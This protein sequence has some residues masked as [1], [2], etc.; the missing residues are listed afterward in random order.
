MSVREIAKRA[1]VSITTVSRVLNNHPSV[2]ETVRES[3]LA[4]A[5]DARYVAPVSRRSTTN[6]A[7][8]YT[9]PSSLGSSFDAALMAGMNDGLEEFGCD[10][11]ILDVVRSRNPGETF[12]QMFMRKGVRGAMLRTTEQ[13]RKLCETI[14]SENFPVLAVADRFDNPA[15]SFIHSDSRNVSRDG[16]EHL[17][18]LGH[19]RIAIS[20]NVVD[21]H[22]HQ[23]RLDGYKEA[24]TAAGIEVDRRLILRVP[25]NREGG[26][27]AMR[28]IMTMVDRP[29]ALFATD[30]MVAAGALGEAR[31]MQVKVPADL[32]IIGFDD[33]EA[34][35]GTFP[36]LTAVCQDA[37][38]LGREAVASLFYLI[39]GQGTVAPVRRSLRTWLEIH[40]STGPAPAPSTAGTAGGEVA[41][42]GSEQG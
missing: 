36:P 37:R 5:N 25:A 19:K 13:T 35:Y 16:I 11:M 18:A 21:D 3:V 8:V 39:E 12:S 17:L 31:V 2:S 26:P 7:F 29:T 22:D 15:I 23:D 33:A 38:R 30:P 24:L 41:I 14:G 6:I 10:L 40:G 9:G 1:G 28:R 32:S 34:R 20:L 42:A 27:Q 4:A